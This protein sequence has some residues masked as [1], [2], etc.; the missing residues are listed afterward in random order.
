MGK[1]FNYLSP[2][3]YQNK[4]IEDILNKLRA[5]KQTKEDKQVDGGKEYII[6]FSDLEELYNTLRI[7]QSSEYRNYENFKLCILNSVLDG[8]EDWGYRCKLVE[9]FYGKHKDK[10][11]GFSIIIREDDDRVIS[12]PRNIMVNSDINVESGGDDM[13]NGESKQTQNKRGYNVKDA[14]AYIVDDIFYGEGYFDIYKQ[15]LLNNTH[16]YMKQEF[17]PNLLARFKAQFPRANIK[18]DDYFYDNVIWKWILHSAKMEEVRIHNQPRNTKRV[19]GEVVVT[20]NDVVTS[21]SNVDNTVDVTET[22]IPEAEVIDTTIVN[23]T[24]ETE[25]NIIRKATPQRRIK[26]HKSKKYKRFNVI[27]NVTYKFGMLGKHQFTFSD[28]VV[29]MTAEEAWNHTVLLLHKIKGNASKL[30]IDMDSKIV[31]EIE[32]LG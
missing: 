22:A 25:P 17:K 29:A 3:D 5:C 10:V 7:P 28:T 19:D 26:V 15:A 8:L 24:T 20:E 14:K 4:I 16:R 30:V 32:M 18:D 1:G 31:E 12:E 6:G 11:D 23:N 21:E 13:V 27:V 2:E 9:S